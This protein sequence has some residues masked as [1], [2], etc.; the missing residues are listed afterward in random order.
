MLE[1]LKRAAPFLRGRLAREVTL[2]FTPAL[3]FEID[4]SFAEAERIE[5]ILRDVTPGERG[6]DKGGANESGPDDD[7]MGDGT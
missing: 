2:K 6:P 3:Q 7:G 5:T 1:A 4:T